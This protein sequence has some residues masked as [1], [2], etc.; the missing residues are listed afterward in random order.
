MQTHGPVCQHHIVKLKQIQQ[1][2][3]VDRQSLPGGSDRHL[4]IIGCKLHGTTLQW[5]HDEAKLYTSQLCSLMKPLYH[6]KGNNCSYFQNNTIKR[7]AK[8]QRVVA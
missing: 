6:E 2:V 1:T 5:P 4:A 3:D 8:K 7:L